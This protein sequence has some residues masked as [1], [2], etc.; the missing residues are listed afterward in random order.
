MKQSNDKK[1]KRKPRKKAV[2]RKKAAQQ[3][4]ITQYLLP[5]SKESGG[6]SQPRVK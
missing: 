2:R 1:K 6:P 4:R 5:L 3:K